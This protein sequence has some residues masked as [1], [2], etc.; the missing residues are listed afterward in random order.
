MLLQFTGILTI[1]LGD[2]A[3]SVTSLYREVLSVL[4]LIPALG[5]ASIVGRRLGVHRWSPT[6]SKTLEGSLAFVLSV[7]A[8]VLF[9]RLFG[10]VEPFSVCLNLFKAFGV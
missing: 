5:Q 6:T 3:V 1:G 2:A 9:L 7:L 8:A 10:Y 4:V